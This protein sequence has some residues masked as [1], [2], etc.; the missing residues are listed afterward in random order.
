M[1]QQQDDEKFPQEIHVENIDIDLDKVS[2]DRGSITYVTTSISK[3]RLSEECQQ[4]IPDSESPG[5]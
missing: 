1:A 3:Q 2:E 5:I 4:A